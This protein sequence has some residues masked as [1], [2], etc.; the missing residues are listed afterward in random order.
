MAGMPR[1]RRRRMSQTSSQSG[2]ASSRTERDWWQNL[3][4][5]FRGG[6]S[7]T[8]AGTSERRGAPQHG[9]LTSLRR[10][11]SG[12]PGLEGTS[13]VGS[14]LLPYS[15]LER[16]F[17]APDGGDGYKTHFEWQFVDNNGDTWTIYDQEAREGRSAEATR[18]KP[19]VH[20]HIGGGSRENVV[21]LKRLLRPG[22][23]K[24]V[25]K[26]K[27]GSSRSRRHK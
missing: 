14:I 15:S 10:V 9:A 25:V 3:K 1:R 21:A 11:P 20:W 6:G 2:R 19:S 7:R 24:S 13:R 16:Q 4:S 5:A 17:G 12:S 26:K 23:R 8:S 22:G 27:A 18:R